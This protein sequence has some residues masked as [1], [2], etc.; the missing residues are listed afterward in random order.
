MEKT[1]VDMALEI[2]NLAEDNKGQ[3]VCVLDVSKL[4]SWTD[5]FVIVTV[6]S[7]VHLRALAE[8]IKDYVK[9]T[10]LEIHKVNRKSPQGD[11]WDLIDLGP[12]VV[13]LMSRDARD[14][15]DLEN[16]WQAGKKI[17]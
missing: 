8:K 2:A 10:P 5:F 16:L 4:N 6:L 7:G 3:N 1:L 15:Y 17:R 12:I 14:F 13:H 9:D 11:E